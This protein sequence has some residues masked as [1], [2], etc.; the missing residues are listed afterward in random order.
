MCM[1]KTL[2]TEPFS[3]L[4]GAEASVIA[5]EAEAVL[6]EV[7]GHI[8][9]AQ[10]AALYTIRVLLEA[11]TTKDNGDDPLADTPHDDLFAR[12]AKKLEPPK[13]VTGRPFTKLT[14]LATGDDGELFRRK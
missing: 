12:I 10:K 3:H 8:T 7:N 2:T 11:Q 4:R 14:K 9:D 5:A 6:A 1:S 13:K